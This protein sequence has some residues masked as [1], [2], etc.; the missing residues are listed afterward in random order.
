[1]TGHGRWDDAS[2][3][4]ASFHE[5]QEDSDDMSMDDDDNSDEEDE[6]PDDSGHEPDLD[7]D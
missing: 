4:D 2:R 6:E 1:M 5:A 7:L 3:F